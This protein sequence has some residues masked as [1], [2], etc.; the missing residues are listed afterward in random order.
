MA[1]GE[2]VDQDGDSTVGG[3]VRGEIVVHNDRVSVREFDAVTSSGI[4][5]LARGQ[6]SS[7]QRLGVP[8]P[9]KRVGLEWR[10]IESAAA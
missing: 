9:Q 2:A 3:P 6:I 7:S 8:V 10:D 5:I 1:S 4:R